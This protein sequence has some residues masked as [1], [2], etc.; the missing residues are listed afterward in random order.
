MTRLLFALMAGLLT[1]LV[2][3]YLPGSTHYHL[4]E[5]YSFR[6]GDQAAEVR[7]AVMIPTSGP[8]QE[9][10]NV[11][12]SWDGT[13]ATESHPPVEVVKLAGHIQARAEKT[14]T[15]AYDV[16]LYQGRARW[17]GPTEDFQLRPQP[18]IESEEPALM[19]AAAKLAAGTSREEAYRLYRFT[20]GW[21]AWYGESG[22]DP[23]LRLQSARK[24]YQTRQGVCGHFANLMT[25]LCRAAHIPAQSI[26]G[27]QLPAYPPLWSA[28][29]VWGSPAGTHGWVEF[30]TPKGW[31]LAD[32]SAAHWQPLK[33]LAF[34]RTDGGHLS[35]GERIAQDRTYEAMEAWAVAKGAPIGGMTGPLRFMATADG[36]VSVVP[37]GTVKVTWSSRWFAVVVLVGLLLGGDLGWGWWRRRHGAGP[38]RR[39]PEPPPGASADASDASVGP[40]S[41]S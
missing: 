4:Q 22:T 20:A 6:A 35:F 16:V 24:A 17:E 1:L 36:Q 37:R 30:H 39:S 29:R 11:V 27:L 32:P 8:Y 25:A 23:S 26:S 34:G 38:T 21:L 18:G 40:R 15:V 19:Q 5:T 7:L 3:L 14:A 12:I 33:S 31:E 2:W 13:A 41:V 9:V 28:T 10:K